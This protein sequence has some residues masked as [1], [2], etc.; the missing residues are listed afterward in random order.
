MEINKTLKFWWQYIVTIFNKKVTKPSVAPPQ[1]RALLQVRL[2][3][4]MPLWRYHAKTN[5]VSRVDLKLG[6]YDNSG[7]IFRMIW[8]EDCLYVPALTLK[9]AEDKFK[10][11]VEKIAR[12]LQEE[13]R[14]KKGFFK[15]LAA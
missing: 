6:R 10:I 1:N 14:K 12:R 9:R 3:P 11:Q 15:K 7:S 13:E 4:G 5:K 2:T 8:E